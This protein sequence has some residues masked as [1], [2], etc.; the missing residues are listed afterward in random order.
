MICDAPNF[1]RACIGGTLGSSQCCT[2]ARK[3]MGRAVFREYR[4]TPIVA[5]RE[6]AS[7]VGLDS[8]VHPCPPRDCVVL[9]KWS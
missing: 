7:L 4:P 2:A 8:T 9:G 5:S 6:T 3:T 1:A